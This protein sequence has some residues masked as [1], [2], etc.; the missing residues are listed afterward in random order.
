MTAEGMERLQTEFEQVNIKDLNEEELFAG[1][2][3]AGAAWSPEEKS[4]VVRAYELASYVHRDE[5]HRGQ[6]YIYH[7]LR[8]AN[9]ITKYLHLTNAD[10]IAGALLHDTIEHD[11]DTVIK[12]VARGTVAPNYPL[13]MPSDPE[14]KQLLAFHAIAEQFSMRTSRMVRGMTNPPTQIDKHQDREAWLVEYEQ[15][16]AEDIREPD[17][18]IGRWPDWADNGLS[19][20]FGTDDVSPQRRQDYNEKYGRAML[21][22]EERFYHIDIQ[23]LLDNG[24]KA[25][26]IRSFELARERLHVPVSPRRLGDLVVNHLEPA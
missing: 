17:V 14:E 9:R 22:L 10:Q 13:W 26:I 6:P 3:E 19:W 11:P 18:F 23:S 7:P 2:L 24:A 15:R 21:V 20:I 25:N 16:L 5:Q 8:V 4:R 1:L 12:Y